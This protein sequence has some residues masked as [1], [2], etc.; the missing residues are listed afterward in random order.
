MSW[1]L[2]IRNGD[3]TPAGPGGLAIVTGSQKLIQD[4]KHWILEQRGSDPMHPDY[5]STLDG[6]TLPDGTIIPTSIGEIVDRER[7]MAIE[8]ELRRILIAYQEQQQERLQREANLYGG[9]NTFAPGEILADVVSVSVDQIEDKV[10]AFVRLTTESGQ[11][12][13]FAQPV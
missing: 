12:V 11:S 6:G 9:K 4:L 13:E 7:L 10:V 1:S 5:G 2:Y 3:L 8:S